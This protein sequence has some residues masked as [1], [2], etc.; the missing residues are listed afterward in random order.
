MG[1]CI[2]V[3]DSNIPCQRFASGPGFLSWPI[4]GRLPSDRKSP[5]GSLV[6]GT[7]ALL[8]HLQR[9]S[10]RWECRCCLA[11]AF[12][13][14]S[15][16]RPLASTCLPQGHSWGCHVLVPSRWPTATR[17]ASLLSLKPIEEIGAAWSQSPAWADT[18]ASRRA[19]SMD[20]VAFS[21]REFCC[22]NMKYYYYYYYYYYS[23]LVFYH[24]VTYVCIALL[25][26]S[27]ILVKNR[28]FMCLP[29]ESRHNRP[30]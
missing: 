29:L 3:R 26:N 11:V 23:V 7:C 21:S 22:F 20:D 13:Q 8:T 16:W 6:A 30:I 18:A 10:L 24:N 5:T 19:W 28:A 12:L 1:V 14:A 27:H 15:P 17:L 4:R 9:I 25:S 2:S